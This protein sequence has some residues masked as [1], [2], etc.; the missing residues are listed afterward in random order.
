M[1]KKFH[2][3]RI[4]GVQVPDRVMGYP[5]GGIFESTEY[6]RGYGESTLF[7]TKQKN[8]AEFSSEEDA[9]MHVDQLSRGINSDRESAGYTVIGISSREGKK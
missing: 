4:S 6:F 5:G 3:Y 7:G 9:R 1:S 2:I 8:A